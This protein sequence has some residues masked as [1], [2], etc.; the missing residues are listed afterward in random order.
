MNGDFLFALEIKA[1]LCHPQVKRQADPQ[2]LADLLSFGYVPGPATLFA[3]IYKV[4]PSDW[5]LCE[6]G[7]LHEECYWDYTFGPTEQR[8]IEEHIRGICQHVHRAVE[9]R[10]IA[11]VPVG[12]LLRSGG[13][14]P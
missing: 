14:D 8:P 13:I 12:T 6:N 11:D 1:L 3:N 4:L 7:R 10:M 2:A 9:E 5:L